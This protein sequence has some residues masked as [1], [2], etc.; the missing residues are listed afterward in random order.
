MKQSLL[1]LSVCLLAVTSC[2]KKE[3]PFKF[4]GTIQ[5]LDYNKCSCCGGYIV[6]VNGS[7]SSY[8]AVRL[9]M[10]TTIDTNSHFPIIIDFNYEVM[11]RCATNNIISITGLIAKY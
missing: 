8:R 4:S 11:D 9:P 3:S 10:G 6:K 2:K 7:D 1:L 5:G